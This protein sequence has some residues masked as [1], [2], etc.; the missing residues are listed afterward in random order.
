[1]PTYVPHHARDEKQGKTT[2]DVGVIIALPEELNYFLKYIEE[3]SMWK[4]P[5]SVQQFWVDGYSFWSIHFHWES[6]ER[7]Q[8]VQVV[9]Y[10]VAEMGSE[11]T[12]AATS[13]LIEKWHVPFIVNIGVT[14]SLDKD[15]KVG[16][17][18]IPTQITHYSANW[19]VRDNGQSTEYIVGTRAFATNRAV[20]SQFSNFMVTGDYRE[21]QN[22]CTSKVLLPLSKEFGTPEIH[23][24]HV[25][26]GHLVVDSKYYKEELKR[27]DRKLVACEMETA[28]FMIAEQFLQA[29]MRA[30][31]SFIALRCISDMAADKAEAEDGT[32]DIKVGDTVVNN[33]ELA[34]RNAT[35]LFQHLIRKRVIN[36][37]IDAQIALLTD[38][39]KLLTTRKS[40]TKKR[41]LS[42]SSAA[43]L[44]NHRPMTKSDF[45]KLDKRGKIGFIHSLD[46]NRSHDQLSMM[47]V[48]QLNEIG[49]SLL[50]NNNLL[51]NQSR[52]VAS[53]PSEKTITTITCTD[54][55]DVDHDIDMD[56]QS[57]DELSS[58]SD[59]ES[60]DN[61]GIGTDVD[62]QVDKTT[63]M[64]LCD[65]TSHIAS[66]QKLISAN[67][68]VIVPQTEYNEIMRSF[69]GLLRNVQ[70]AI[71]TNNACRQQDESIVS[72]ERRQLEQVETANEERKSKK[73]RLGER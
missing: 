12:V 53:R 42:V 36:A 22:L 3:S 18:V 25:A 10:L 4:D 29:S 44:V 15:V 35:I 67:E 73:M 30:V 7:V 62:T 51:K 34:M 8:I 64:K 66:L 50:M 33:R 38:M 5:P 19:K 72:E 45:N 46:P 21:W 41:F 57:D 27:T 24:G 20:V 71:R 56:T 65:L 70:A 68:L 17:V 43:N 1:M 61:D 52:T 23:L 49:L 69:Q 37:D 40:E 16:S 26:S 32:H 11:F 39:T 2:F 60:D 47:S 55:N 48:A 54:G 63:G 31:S 59:T 28:G 6:E 13:L 9:V 58:E 14:G